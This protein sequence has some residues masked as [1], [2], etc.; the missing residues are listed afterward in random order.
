MLYHA[1]N[2]YYHGY[3]GKHE[4]DLSSL[5][6]GPMDHRRYKL[7][8]QGQRIVALKTKNK[9]MRFKRSYF[10]VTTPSE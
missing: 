7:G 3:Q 6:G 5:S 9:T 1:K 8:W 2:A 4:S 10:W